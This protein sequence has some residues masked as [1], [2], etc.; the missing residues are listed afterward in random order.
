MANDPYKYFR[1]EA[2]EILDQLGKGVLD[3]EKSPSA[4]EMVA[5]L[6]RLAHTLKGAARVVKQRE[7]A[8]NCDTLE[9]VLATYRETPGPVPHD[10]IDLM[11]KLA[12]GIG[13]CI[14]GLAPRPDQVDEL[15]TQQHVEI[16]LRTVRADI[17]E[18]D[19][20]LDGVAEAHTQLS[21][22]QRSLGSLERARHLVDLA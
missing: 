1:V 16:P 10:Q 20:L 2:R 6:L 15:P 11:L 7:I 9:D 19:E 17:A 21:F 18:V 4:P 13:K 22:L 12:D 5:R 8:D 3:L 14:G